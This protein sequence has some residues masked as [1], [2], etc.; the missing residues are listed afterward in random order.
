VGHQAAG[1]AE[2]VLSLRVVDRLAPLFAEA[3]RHRAHADVADL[4]DRIATLRAA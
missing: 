2:Q 4:A 1:L 3:Q